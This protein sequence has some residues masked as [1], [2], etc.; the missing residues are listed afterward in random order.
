MKSQ[1]INLLL[2]KLCAGICQGFDLSSGETHT[3]TTNVIRVAAKENSYIKSNVFGEDNI[4][5]Y[6]P[7]GAI[8]YFEVNVDDII[9]LISG[10]IN[11]SSIS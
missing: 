11:I 1:K 10:S 2:G 3:C 5:I 7:A 4:G 6:L 8:E 9:T